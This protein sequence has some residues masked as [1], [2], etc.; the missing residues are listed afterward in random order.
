MTNVAEPEPA[1]P[2]CSCFHL[3][4]DNAETVSFLVQDNA[5]P[6]SQFVQDYADPVFFLVQDYADTRSPCPGV[7]KHVVLLFQDNG[8]HRDRWPLVQDNA[9]TVSP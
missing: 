9:D 4:P 6:V 5:D 1:F 2:A 8:R 3:V 7:C